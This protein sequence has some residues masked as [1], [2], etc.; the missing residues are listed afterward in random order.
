MIRVNRPDRLPAPSP[1][2]MRSTA[3]VANE[4]F[5][6]TDTPWVT[7]W[8]VRPGTVGVRLPD[9]PDDLLTHLQGLSSIGVFVEVED[10]GTEATR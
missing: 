1:F 4:V 8:T 5:R 2:G 3:D 9:P 6:H 10:A 7:V